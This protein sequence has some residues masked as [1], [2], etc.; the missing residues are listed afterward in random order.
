[1][2]GSGLTPGADFK[3]VVLAP[4]DMPLALSRGEIDGYIVAEPFG[5]KAELLGIGKVF[6]FSKDIWKHHPDCV[7]VMREEYL[8]SYP[9]AALELVRSLINSGIFAEENREEAVR[10]TAAFL[11]HSEEVIAQ[12]LK[13]PKDRVIFYDLFPRTEEFTR[14]QDYMSEKMGLF[15]Q[16]ADLDDLVD[17]SFARR[18]YETIGK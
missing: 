6:V 2:S 16:K 18:A 4:S 15:E 13:N 17:A 5:A 7:L 14:I 12:A 11:G 3:T 1:M 8:K 10:I 9:Q